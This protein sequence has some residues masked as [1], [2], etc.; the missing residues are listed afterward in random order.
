MVLLRGHG[1]EVSALMPKDQ[2]EG[3]QNV[4]LNADPNNPAPFPSYLSL[5]IF[6]NC[7][8]SR[9]TPQEWLEMG[10]EDGVRKPVPGRALLPTRDDVHHCKCTLQ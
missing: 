2:P 6:D 8:Y 7:E 9:R 1:I 5:E 3:T 10:A 4:K